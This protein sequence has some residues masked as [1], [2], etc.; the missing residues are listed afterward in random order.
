MTDRWEPKDLDE[1]R[2]FVENGGASETRFYEFKEQLPPNNQRV[3]KQLA[4]FAIDGGSLVIGVAE[5]EPG[6]FEVRPI[7]HAELREKVDSIARSRVDP[8]LFVDPKVLKDRDDDSRGVLWI[9]V[10]PSPDAPHQVDGVYYE[11][12]ATQT[13]P[14]KDGAIER[15]MAAR[16]KS[17][18]EIRSKLKKLMENDPI[19]NGTTAHVFGIA[20][21]VGAGPEDLYD[22]VGGDGSWSVFYEG[23]RRISE[24][25]PLAPGESAPGAWRPWYSLCP[26][27]QSG[28][29]GPDG[30]TVQCGDDDHGL[31]MSYGEDGTV[32]YVNNVGSRHFNNVVSR[33]ANVYFLHPEMIV[34]SC[35]DVL[36]AARAVARH[37]G[38]RRSWDVGFG[39][40]GTEGLHAHGSPS[41]LS[42]ASQRPFPDPSYKHVLRVSH[43]ELETDVWGVARKLTRRF[44]R[45]CDRKF[46]Q[47]ARELGYQ[48]PGAAP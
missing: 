22:A 14:M 24:E 30:Y 16:R 13:S 25:Y 8:P 41:W 34:G 19:P 27:Y 10:P 28:D 32:R 40:T 12:G 23:A 21:P 17:T 3:A 9:A 29:S 18:E 44:L 42:R 15:L 46:E 2:S 26:P 36:D 45:G 37:T 43:Q 11:R 39:L 20:E 4:G 31:W 1:L 48:D 35:L 33:P 7:E 47:M 5:P 6:R 38:Q